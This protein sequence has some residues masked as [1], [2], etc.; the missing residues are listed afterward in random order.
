MNA[1]ATLRRRPGRVWRVV[2][3]A[4]TRL[5]VAIV[6]VVGFIIAVQACAH[7]FH[8]A[9]STGPGLVVA[10]LQILGASGVYFAYVRVVERRP[11]TELGS[12]GA[13]REFGLGALIGAIL[14]SATAL[15]LWLAGVWRFDGSNAWTVLVYP[16]A[17]ALAAAF[18]EE[19]L[20]RGIVFRIVEESLGSW[21][22]LAFSAAIFGALHGFNPGATLV[23]SVAIALEAGVLLA[24]AYMYTRRLWLPIGLHF[25]WNFTEGSIFG[26]SVSGGET[27]GLLISRLQGSALLTGDRFGPEASIVAV[28]VCL[29]AAVVFIV[30]AQRSRCIVAPV[31]RRA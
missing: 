7:A 29:A 6:A 12:S 18:T 13:V 3:F 27:H 19:I 20:C 26:A 15:I 2:Q 28:L 11:V 1:V 17:S 9:P 16:L 10:L 8:I 30:L 31:W 25:A 22:A 14:F 4:P 5:V 23:S 21:L 24:A